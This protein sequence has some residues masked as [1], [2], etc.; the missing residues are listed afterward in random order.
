VQECFDK[1]SPALTGDV[2]VRAGPLDEYF[3]QLTLSVSHVNFLVEFG[4]L[5]ASRKLLPRAENPVEGTE[6]DD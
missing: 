1:L 2:V 3:E 4:R 6:L 5:L